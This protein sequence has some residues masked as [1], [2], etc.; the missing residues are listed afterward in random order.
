MYKDIK[1]AFELLL[2]EKF[3]MTSSLVSIV[4]KIARHLEMIYGQRSNRE[5]KKGW[6]LKRKKEKELE[7][8]FCCFLCD[9]FCLQLRK[10]RGCSL[11]NENNKKTS[12]SIFFRPGADPSTFP[13]LTFFTSKNLF[14]LFS[15]FF[16]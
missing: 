1:N 5:R 4:Q 6:Y 3:L 10:K 9:T 15:C 16:A 11:N 8:C 14:V 13:Y 2:M 12:Y 7:M